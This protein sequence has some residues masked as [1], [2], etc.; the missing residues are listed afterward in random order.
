ML[1]K[2]ILFLP[3]IFCLLLCAGCNNDLTDANSDRHTVITDS[4]G[5]QVSLPQTVTKV[6]VANR[7]NMEII[8]SLGVLDRV[9]GVDYGIYQDQAAYGEF[10][11]KEQVIGKSQNDL[12]YEKIIELQPQLLILTGNGAWQD[13]AKKL[14]P[15]GIRIIV[16]DAYYTSAFEHTYTLAGQIFQQ[17]AKAAAFISYFQ[18]KLQYIRTALKNVP[19]KTVYYEYRNM[20]TTTIPGDYFFEMLEYAHADNIF[21][22]AKSTEINIEAVVQQNP[23]A[24]VKVGA[25]GVDPKYIPP[26]AADFLQRHQELVE[27]PGWTAIKAVQNDKILLLSQYAH[28]GASKLVGTMYIAK[29]LYPEYLPDLHPEQVF[30]DWVTKYQH[31]DYRPGH[32]DPPFA[33]TD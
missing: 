3:L 11:S 7:Y 5:R 2:K 10:F 8:K 24:I 32:T 29:F 26:T 12:N 16:M 17:E 23:D 9:V 31:L 20:G 21:R 33:L 22:D 15:F 1:I 4:I 30:K 14:E 6:A 13:A 19:K 25:A 28:G 27:R 18:D